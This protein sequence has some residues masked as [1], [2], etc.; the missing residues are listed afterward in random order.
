MK[1]LKLKHISVEAEDKEVVRDVSLE[2][3][4]GEVSVLMGPNGCG[5]STLVNAIFGHPHYSVTKGKLLLDGKDVL[6]LRPDEKARKGLFLSLQHLPKVGGITLATFLHK[7]HTAATDTQTDI[8]E[9]Y[10]TLRER[11]K[12]LGIRDDLLDRSLTQGLSGGEKKLSEVLQLAVLKPRFAILDE[13]DSGVDVDAIR[14]VFAAVETLRKE[15]TGFLIISHHP[16]LLDHVTPKHVHLMAGGKLVRSA[17]K[18]LAQEVHKN[19]FCKAIEC[20]LEPGC[21]AKG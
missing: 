20:P 11:A 4:E 8:L 10:L 13:I 5:K 7:I 3:A 14:T 15:G 6:K 17:G 18:E 16:S 2:L 1:S 21:D 9:Y 12:E 19:G